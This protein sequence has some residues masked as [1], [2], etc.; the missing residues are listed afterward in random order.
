MCGHNRHSGNWHLQWVPFN[1]NDANGQ[2]TLPSPVIQT[3]T[4]H[5]N[6]AKPPSAVPKQ[7][8]PG[9][10][11]NTRHLATVLRT[12]VAD[13]KWRLATRIWQEDSVTLALKIC[14]SMTHPAQQGAPAFAPSTYLLLVHCWICDVQSVN[15]HINA[16][17]LRPLPE[18]RGG[19]EVNDP[20]HCL[21]P[22]SNPAVKC[23]GNRRG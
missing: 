1:S 17:C 10:L 7:K 21:G 19:E 22:S 2:A 16:C 14:S 18:P 20:W 8:S 6:T 23:N 13:W 3:E 4:R 15:S 5:L 11:W 12:A 9:R